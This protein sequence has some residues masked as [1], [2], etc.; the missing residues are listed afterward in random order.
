MLLQKIGASYDS[1]AVCERTVSFQFKEAQF[2]CIGEC[3]RPVER[4]SN[5]LV[6]QFAGR[7]CLVDWYA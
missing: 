1:A 2:L 4:V 3:F 6:H 7:V 5:W